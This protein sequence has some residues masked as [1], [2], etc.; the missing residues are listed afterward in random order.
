[1][2]TTT[3]VEAYKN[4]A[5]YSSRT[6]SPF[7]QLKILVMKTKLYFPLRIFPLLSALCAPH[8]KSLVW[9]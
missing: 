2:L 6:D 7:Y 8:Y 5:I 9:D 4:R 1:M 3:C